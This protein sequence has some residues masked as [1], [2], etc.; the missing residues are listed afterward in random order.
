[1][2]TIPFALALAFILGCT[3]KASETPT[4]APAT[5]PASA[6]TESSTATPETLHVAGEPLVFAPP[7]DWTVEAPTSR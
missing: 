6:A 3:T 7:A 5:T 2:N 4:P 1:M